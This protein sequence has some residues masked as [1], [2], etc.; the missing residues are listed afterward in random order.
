PNGR[1]PCRRVDL[2]NAGK[3]FDYRAAIFGPFAELS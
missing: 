3:P 2:I 1:N